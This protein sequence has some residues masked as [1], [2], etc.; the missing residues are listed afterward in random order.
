EVETYG[1]GMRHGHV[2]HPAY[3]R[4]IVGVTEL[5]D[6]GLLDDDGDG[7]ARR[8]PIRRHGGGCAAASSKALAD[9]C[10]ARTD[11]ASYVLGTPQQSPVDVT[12]ESN[13]AAARRYSRL[14]EEP[15][16]GAFRPSGSS[17]GAG[18]RDDL[19]PT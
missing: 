8:R 13:C 3:I 17:S 9:F 12:P 15:P 4:D 5:I 16:S 7:E 1:R 11:R 19:D 10:H 2:L 6:V 14:P 18:G